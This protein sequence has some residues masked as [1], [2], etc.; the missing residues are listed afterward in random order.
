MCPGIVGK[1]FGQKGFLSMENYQALID[2]VGDYVFQ[3]LFWN[4]GE[5]FI[6]KSFLDMVR[7]AKQKGIMAVAST[8]GYFI[9][10]DEEAEN[11][12]NSGLDQ[13][14]FSMDGTNQESYEKYRVGGNFNQVLG[15]LKR[16]SEARVRL[17]SK[18][19]MIELQFIVFK[20]NQQEIDQ[21]IKMAKTF[22]IDR[23]SLKS[24]MIYIAEQSEK[25][26]DK[27]QMEALYKI[28]NN[29]IS[30]CDKLPN[31]CDRL[32]LNGVV[33]WDG[34]VVPCCF[35]TDN[36]YVFENIFTSGIKYTKVWRNKAYQDFRASVLKDRMQNDIC[37]NC[38]EG[39]PEP[40]AKIVDLW[41][42]S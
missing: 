23:L 40:Y 16:L 6:H 8:N 2:D 9:R 5:P 27:D 14:I 24:A 17:K 35:D 15:G 34:T 37:R 11:I 12:I 19:P 31:R 7:Y 1:R 30:R 22:H 38:T 3:I 42:L 20:H 4:Q 13:L 26:L 33:N 28:E 18:T 39:V 36:E 29:E 41:D 10:N 21:L 32:W 25:F